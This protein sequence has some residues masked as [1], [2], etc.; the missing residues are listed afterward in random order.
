MKVYQLTLETLEGGA[1]LEA[2]DLAIQRVVDDL[3]D[4]DKLEDETRSVVITL[5]FQ[6]TK[7]PR[8]PQVTA[9]VQ[10][11]LA[12]YRPIAGQAYLSADADGQIV[13]HQVDPEQQQLPLETAATDE[14]G[15]ANVAP[16]RREVNGD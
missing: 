13:A 14:G 2:T 3:I 6:P 15:P 9:S 1:V 10:P 7:N 12:K 4:P 8:N 5:R 16:L 11:K